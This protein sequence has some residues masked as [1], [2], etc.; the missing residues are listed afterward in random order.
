VVAVSAKGLA[1]RYLDANGR[2]GSRLVGAAELLGALLV[3]AFG[4]AM[5]STSF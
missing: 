1:R 2:L 4:L 5:L 3:L